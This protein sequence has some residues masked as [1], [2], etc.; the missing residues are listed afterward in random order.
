M[1]RNR[2]IL[3]PDKAE[4]AAGQIIDRIRIHGFNSIF[5]QMLVKGSQ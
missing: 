3:L 4:A 1:L 2:L 5:Q